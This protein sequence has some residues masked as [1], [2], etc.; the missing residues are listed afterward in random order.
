MK[1]SPKHWMVVENILQA[2][3]SASSTEPENLE[4]LL[5]QRGNSP[6]ISVARTDGVEGDEL[7]TVGLQPVVIKGLIHVGY[8]QETS[9]VRKEEVNPAHSF[10][11]RGSGLRVVLE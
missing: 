11:T 6:T 9:H 3:K 7:S 5:A 8:Q 10:S 1:V 4:A 2:T